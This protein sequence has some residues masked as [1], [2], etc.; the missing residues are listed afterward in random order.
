VHVDGEPH[1][2]WCEDVD[3]GA[4]MT[5]VATNH[6]PD[7]IMRAGKD[8]LVEDLLTV[9][10]TRAVHRTL[11]G[12]WWNDEYAPELLSLPRGVIHIERVAAWTARQVDM[13]TSRV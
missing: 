10:W 3:V 9:A 13:P 6:F 4:T 7:R 12:V 8:V 5:A 2:A 1:V 11:D